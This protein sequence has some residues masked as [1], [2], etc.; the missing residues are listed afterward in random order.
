MI[1][2]DI[3]VEKG[4]KYMFIKVGHHDK[5]RLPAVIL[6]NNADCSGEPGRF[7]FEP[8]TE[9]VTTYTSKD[10]KKQMVGMTF[11]DE[12]GTQMVHF[13]YPGSAM[14]PPGYELDFFK[15]NYFKGTP[16]TLQGALKR[17]EKNNFELACQPL[18]SMKGTAAT[19]YGSMRIRSK[20]TG[21]MT[22][23]WKG[24]TTSE[25]QIYTFSVG[26]KS[27]D[28]QTSASDSAS[29]MNSAL[30]S[31]WDAS[32]SAGAKVGFMGSGASVKVE[33]GMHGS[34]SSSSSIHASLS[35]EIS[36]TAGVD[37]TT[38]HQTSC[39]PKQGESGSG[40]WQWV[41]ST[42][43]YSTAAFTSHTVCRTGKL[44]R[45][46]PSCSF[47]DCDY[48]TDDQCTSCKSDK[49]LATAKLESAEETSETEVRNDAED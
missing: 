13:G 7:T 46:P 9:P 40:L 41:L 39:T 1:V 14:V 27:T 37:K 43:D 42:S 2:E 25:A 28:A 47:D 36:A 33:G 3:Q 17:Q 44:A 34:E 10:I 26:I 21:R 18:T 35:K 5:N 23:Y 30:E 29:T 49:I 4:G 8:S 32:V 31:G 6:F 20:K 45:T 15:S 22:G 16:E 19:E 24:I 48:G 12:K 38:T 11:V